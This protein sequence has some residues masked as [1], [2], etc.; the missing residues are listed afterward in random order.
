VTSTTVARADAPPAIRAWRAPLGAHVAALALVLLALVPLLGTSRLFSADEGALDAQTHLLADG[1]GWFLDHP[2]PDLDDDGRLF[3]IHLSDIDAG[4]DRGA[5]F[6]KHP[7]YAVALAPLAGL[8]G[9]TAMILTSLAGTL[10]A[11]FVAARLSRR[12]RPGLERPTLWAVGLA[13]PMF[14][15]SYVLIAHTLGAALVGSAVLLALQRD[16]G[17]RMP[18]GVFALVAVAV[19]LRTE[20]ALFG[21]ALAAACAVAAWLLRE[22]NLLLAGVAA[23]AGAVGGKVLDVVLGGLVVGDRA[24][25]A[26]PSAGGGDFVGDRVYGAVVTWLLPSYDGL[27]VDD[28]L[29]AAA[30]LFAVI[31]V[32]IARKRPEDGPGIRLFAGLGAACAL[33]RL[34]MPASAVPGL[35]V[36]FPLATAGLAALDGRTLRERTRLVAALTYGL[37]ALAVLATQYRTGGTGEWGA[38]YFI[39]GL[40]LLVPLALAALADLGER[41][42]ATTRRTAV[43]ALA[44]G[45]LAL[46]VVA[47]TSLSASQWGSHDA[48]QAVEAVAAA[49]PDAVVVATDGTTGRFGWRNVVDGDEWLLALEIEDLDALGAELADEDRPIVLVTFDEDRIDVLEDDYD[50]VERFR[51]DP[52]RSRLIFTLVPR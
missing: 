1:K 5:P 11:A 40:P 41:L 29:L 18:L 17:V 9:R 24:A 7:V 20:A 35:L 12:M 3:P 15:Y 50:V 44:V 16:R 23:G 48:I 51:P 34:A 4:G 25:A 2:R 13:S 47:G 27:G 30:A 43:G 37:F 45:S 33:G 26:A 10:V 19:T 49:N 36:A 38:R 39:L 42:D 6:A 8:G 52:D 32:A 46:A 31:A 21:L 14:L 28:A 22:R